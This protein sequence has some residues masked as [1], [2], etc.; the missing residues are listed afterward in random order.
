MSL[1][2]FLFSYELLCQWNSSPWILITLGTLDTWWRHQMETFS[3]LLV[4]VRGSPRSMVNSPHKDQ[5]RGTFDVFFDLSLNKQFS[6]QSWDWRFETPLC[7]LWRHCNDMPTGISPHDGCR[8]HVPNSLAP[9]SISSV[10]SVDRVI[11][12]IWEIFLLMQSTIVFA[13]D[14]FCTYATLIYHQRRRWQN[15]NH[16]GGPLLMRKPY[17]TLWENTHTNTMK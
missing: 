1:N 7:S 4:H 13:C 14:I 5:W 3:A 11:H 2:Y 17:E 12:F 16:S 10:Y 6:K 15:D 8:C 9:W